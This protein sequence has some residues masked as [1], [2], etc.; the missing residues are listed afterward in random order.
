MFF[1]GEVLTHILQGLD[2]AMRRYLTYWSPAMAALPFV[3]NSLLSIEEV[4]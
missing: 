2:L 3:S 4:A 1:H